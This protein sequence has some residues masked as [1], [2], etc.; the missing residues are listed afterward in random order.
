MVLTQ[1]PSRKS[2]R[3]QGARSAGGSC[4]FMAGWGA[5]LFWVWVNGAEEI[6]KALSRHSIQLM[7][8]RGKHD[9][10]H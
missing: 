6:S 5:F 10:G 9:S 7:V 3:D 4:W 1:N 2:W 8:Q